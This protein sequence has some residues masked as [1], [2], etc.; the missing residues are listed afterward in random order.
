MTQHPKLR[1]QLPGSMLDLL[2][3]ALESSRRALSLKQDDA[4]T[5]LFVTIR[6][7]RFPPMHRFPVLCSC[8]KG[9]RLIA[10]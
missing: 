10:N 2:N 4:D 5:L 9:E 1:G 8:E 7:S 3:A 6:L